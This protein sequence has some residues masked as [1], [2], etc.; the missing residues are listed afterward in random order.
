LKRFECVDRSYALVGRFICV[1]AGGAA[2]GL[3]SWFASAAASV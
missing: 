1:V 3:R 2:L